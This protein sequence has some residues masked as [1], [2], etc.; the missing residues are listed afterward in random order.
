MKLFEA[1]NEVQSKGMSGDPA[2]AQSMIDKILPHNSDGSID[3]VAAGKEFADH[4][5][6][7]A[8]GEPI[9]KADIAALMTVKGQSFFD[10]LAKKP[11]GQVISGMLLNA[12]LA[13]WVTQAL[14]GFLS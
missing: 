13:T 10:G 11:L 3:F 4:L 5:M 7:A 14:S 9:K 1:V 8:R 6:K 12:D 2:K